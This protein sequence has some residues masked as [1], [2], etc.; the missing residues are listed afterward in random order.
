MRT[1]IHMCAKPKISLEK[2]VFKLKNL[3]P[4]IMGQK[5]NDLLTTGMCMFSFRER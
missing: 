1:I 5:Q 2:L 3:A 4:A